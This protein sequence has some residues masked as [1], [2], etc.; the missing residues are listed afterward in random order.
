VKVF[1]KWTAIHVVDVFLP[2][3]W[4]DASHGGV[5]AVIVRLLFPLEVKITVV[6]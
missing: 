1:W 2:I 6:P 4:T 5:M 3:R